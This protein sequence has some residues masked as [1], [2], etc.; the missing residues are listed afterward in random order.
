MKA[1]LSSLLSRKF[2]LAL[3]TTLV[4]LANGHT[5]EA[6]TTVLAYLGVQGVADIKK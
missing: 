1:F 5:L 6:L 4:F 3:G 2:L